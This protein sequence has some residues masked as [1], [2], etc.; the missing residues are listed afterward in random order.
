MN[1]IVYEINA[2]LER[3]RLSD[4]LESDPEISFIPFGGSRESF[5]LLVSLVLKKN[6]L[7]LDL[8]ICLI[9]RAAEVILASG[10]IDE[11]PG[12]ELVPYFNSGENLK[13]IFR[14]SI[15]NQ[16]F[17]LVKNELPIECFINSDF[18]PGIKCGW[19]LERP[20]RL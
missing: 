2:L 8:A 9:K 10:K 5:Y 15:L 17:N 11:F 19:Y 12:L 18:L 16:S 14:L 7:K 13:K 20:S 3:D 6:E 4:F 1:S